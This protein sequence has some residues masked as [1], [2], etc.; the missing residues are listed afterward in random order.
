V[1]PG[2]PGGAT[3]PEAPSRPLGGDPGD[4]AGLPR[5]T[6]DPGPAEPLRASTHTALTHTALRHHRRHRRRRAGGCC[7]RLRSTGSA[8]GYCAQ[9]L[10][11][12]SGRRVQTA[13]LSTVPRAAPWRDTVRAGPRTLDSP[14]RRPTDD[15]VGPA[16]D[17]VAG[18]RT[19]PSAPHGRCWSPPADVVVRDV[20]TGWCTATGEVG[21]RR[22]ARRSVTLTGDAAAREGFPRAAA[23]RHDEADGRSPTAVRGCHASARPVDDLRGRRRPHGVIH[24]YAPHCRSVRAAPPAGHLP[25][26]GTVPRNRGSGRRS[27]S[28]RGGGAGRGRRPRPRSSR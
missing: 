19:T 3:R 2:E 28:G 26:S 14:G 10:S 24:S 12:G 4:D 8:D 16:D 22:G 23:R 7:R 13:V 20:P 25:V 9:V 1:T 27:A 5:A 15:A 6:T 21:A 18:P 17:T 11:T